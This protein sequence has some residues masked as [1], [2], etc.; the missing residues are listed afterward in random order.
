MSLVNY[1][2]F[3][4][5]GFLLLDFPAEL[6]D[7]DSVADKENFVI[8]PFVELLAQEGMES[9]QIIAGG[10]SFENLKGANRIEFKKI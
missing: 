3:N 9:T 5:P 4:Y 8:E 6:E 10:S 7:A 1:S 2:Q